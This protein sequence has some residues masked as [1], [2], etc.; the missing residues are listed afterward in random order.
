[1]PDLNLDF[2][3]YTE[4]PVQGPPSTGQISGADEQTTTST[5]QVSTIEQSQEAALFLIPPF[6][7]PILVAPSGDHHA[8]DEISATSLTLNQKEGW[9]AFLLNQGLKMQQITDDMLDS[10]LKNIKEIEE[11]VRRLLNSPAYLALQE[12][13]LKGDPSQ[14][15]SGI[16]SNTEANAMMSHQSLLS[17]IENAKA[18]E[19]V[20]PNATIPDHN[21]P[22][23]ATKAITIPLVAA[24]L[25]GGALSLGIFELNTSMTG[26]SSNPFIGPMEVV[27]RLQPLYPQ[28]IQ[29]VLP[30]INLAVMPLIYFTSWE[31]SVGNMRNGERESHIAETQNFA[32]QVIKMVSDPAF[33]MVTFVNR[34]QGADQLSPERK[35]Q[36]AA[37]VKLILA[38]VALSLLY[39]V[40]VGKVMDGKF[41][42]IT[43]EEFRGLL[44]GALPIGNPDDPNLTESQRLELTL[45]SQIK[46]QLDI[47]SP[48]Q[49][50]ESIELLFAYLTENKNVE[51]M[52]DPA[53]V[54]SQVL[55][56]GFANSEADANSLG[57][58][59][60]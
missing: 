1:M 40:E 60:V 21:S 54:F 19:R 14:G 48:E 59:R 58:A 41:W 15:I 18:I 53:K 16:Q 10:W 12:I 50:L 44:S 23:D 6:N 46:V 37:M 36:L 13:R 22:D 43:P 4:S 57:N 51:S 17:F 3:D 27:D 26:M 55:E 47:L 38:S 52:L 11:T 25:V 7:F 28:L 30:M 42:G 39:S 56:G 2:H 9:G 31:T 45:L 20:P 32:Q 33:V 8:L 35:D 49:K 29:D 5:S 24:V 34:M